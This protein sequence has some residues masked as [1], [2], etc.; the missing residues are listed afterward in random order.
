MKNIILHYCAVLKIFPC[1]SKPGFLKSGHILLQMDQSF[2][3][4]TTNTIRTCTCLL[5]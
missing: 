4:H 5:I 2:T 1:A 3:T